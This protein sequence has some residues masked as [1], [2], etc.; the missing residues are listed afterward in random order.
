MALITSQFYLQDWADH[1]AMMT[2]QFYLQDWA[3]DVD[4]F[5][6]N[7]GHIAHIFKDRRK[8]IQV[9]LVVNINTLPAGS[10]ASQLFPA[11]ILKFHF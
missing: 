2:S 6:L 1:V 4:S 10:T 11:T 5:L 7:V 9:P 8:V 3:E